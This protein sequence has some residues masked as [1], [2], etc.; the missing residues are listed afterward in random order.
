MHLPTYLVL[1]GSAVLYGVVKAIEL[2]FTNKLLFSAS[3]FIALV[4][5]AGAV[6]QTAHA[7]NFELTWM[8]TYTIPLGLIALGGVLGNDELRDIAL[9]K[10]GVLP[11]P[12]VIP[13]ASADYF[14]AA[15]GHLASMFFPIVAVLIAK[16]VQSLLSIRDSTRNDYDA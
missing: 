10:V 11:P 5:I 9:S 8:R 7:D 13:G 6:V 1:M 3:V 16:I 4:T 14:S 15:Y 2:W 12:H